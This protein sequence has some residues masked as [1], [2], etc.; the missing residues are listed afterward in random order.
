MMKYMQKKL[1]QVHPKTMTGS[2]KRE[3]K[4]IA[5][6]FALHP[7]AKISFRKRQYS[8]YYVKVPQKLISWASI[9][10]KIPN[11]MIAFPVPAMVETATESFSQLIICLFI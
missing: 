9:K 5:K 3:K 4:A 8:P 2:K 1:L 7:N 6:L 11:Y 10:N